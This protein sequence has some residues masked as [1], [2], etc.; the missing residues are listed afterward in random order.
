MNA[1]KPWGWLLAVALLVGLFWWLPIEG[2]VLVSSQPLDPNAQFPQYVFVPSSP[3]PGDEVL[4]NITDNV[5]WT[6]VELMVNDQPATFV[7]TQALPLRQQ[8]SWSWRFTMP[9]L[10]AEDHAPTETILS[11]YR[12]CDS[13]CR[14]RDRRALEPFATAGELLPKEAGLPTK[15]CVDFPDPDRDWHGRSGWGMDLTYAA[16]DVSYWQMDALAGR[17]QQ[18]AEQGLRML[19][20]VDYA[21]QQSLPPTD[22]EAALAL[23]LEHVHR[24]ARDERFAHVYGFIIGTGFNAAD[25]NLLSPEAPTTPEWYARLFN[26]SHTD[27]TGS[28][29]AHDNTVIQIV[30]ANNPHARVLVGPVRPWVSD[31]N[32]AETYRIDAPWLNYM[33]TLVALLDENARRNSAAG[34]PLTEPD[35]FALNVP[36]RPGAVDADEADP[37]LEPTLDLPRTEWN[38]AQSGFRVYQEWLDI[39]NSHPTTRGKPAFIT[40][41]NTYTPDQPPADAA[42]PAQNYPP[43]WLTN[44][45][46]VVNDEPQIQSLCWFLDLIPGDQRWQGYSLAQGEGRMRAAAQEFD[47]LLQE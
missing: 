4:V 29:E 23:Y 19:V 28:A 11:F 1:L 44:A 27:A 31:G 38:G 5:P 34:I 45:L 41:T 33:N 22:D 25:S 43:G 30:R 14:L 18:G 35:G 40:S 24:L 13:G 47:A 39:I 3:R 37:A 8:W 2:T 36:G 9:S 16:A 20:R 6:H 42:L 32:G 26:G 17:V 21:P 12:D 7:E 10:D 15:L 46:S